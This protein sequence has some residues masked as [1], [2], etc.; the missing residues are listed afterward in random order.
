MKSKYKDLTKV[1][2]AMAGV[3]WLL[4]SSYGQMTFAQQP[5]PR[6][7]VGEVSLPLQ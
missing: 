3:L 6:S 7:T 5:D 2:L 4:H 1:T